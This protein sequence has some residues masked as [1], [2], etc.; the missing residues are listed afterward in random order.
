M[1]AHR[2]V[3]VG[4]EDALLLEVLAVLVVH[5]LGVVHDKALGHEVVVT[6]DFDVVH[7][8]NAHRLDRLDANKTE[9]LACVGAEG[10]ALGG[11]V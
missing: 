3:H 4:E 2:G 9:H 10:R 5:D 1:L 8:L 7:R 6:F 11:P